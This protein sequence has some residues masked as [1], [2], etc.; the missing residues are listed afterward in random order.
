MH[1]D[2][3][4]KHHENWCPRFPR[5]NSDFFLLVLVGIEGND[6]VNDI[7]HLE[8]IEWVHHKIPIEVVLRE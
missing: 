3:D 7:D 8:V 2:L 1:A 6:L 4:G 5:E